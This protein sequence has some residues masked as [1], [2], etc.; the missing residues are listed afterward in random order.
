MALMHWWERKF[1][2][3]RLWCLDM[4][5]GMLESQAA[6]IDR[7]RAELLQIRSNVII[8]LINMEGQL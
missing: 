5:I 8:E 3:L 4:D 6:R 1:M 7:D 2:Q